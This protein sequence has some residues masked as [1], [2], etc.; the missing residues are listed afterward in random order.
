[1]TNCYPALATMLGVE[2]GKE[3]RLKARHAEPYPAKY[4]IT[5]EGMLYCYPRSLSWSNVGTNLMQTRIF[6][7]LLRG[8]VEVVK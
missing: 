7:A 5:T 4:Q 8:D 6:C 3:F 2:L 1:M